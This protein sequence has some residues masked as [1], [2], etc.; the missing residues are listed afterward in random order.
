[1][2][3]WLLTTAIVVLPETEP[4]TAFTV[5][6]VPAAAPAS[7]TVATATPAE[8]VVVVS[9]VRADPAVVENV[10]VAPLTAL[11]LASSISAV[12]VAP[13]LPSAGTLAALEVTLMEAT[14]EFTVEPLELLL[15]LLEVVPLLLPPA[16]K[17]VVLPPPQALSANAAIATRRPY[18]R[19]MFT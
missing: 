15:E 6:L 4:T 17:E 8:L 11:L 1:M 3:C 14:V 9:F 16:L 2:D 5:M 7:V 12:T 13:A 19:I 18:L 10:T